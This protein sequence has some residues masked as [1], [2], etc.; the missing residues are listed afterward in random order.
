MGRGAFAAAA[1]E[2]DAAGEAEAFAVGA[3][4]ADFPAA[5]AVTGTQSATAVMQTSVVM[6]DLFFIIVFWLLAGRDGPR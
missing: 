1:G 5:D 4:E 2:A 3:G 6:N